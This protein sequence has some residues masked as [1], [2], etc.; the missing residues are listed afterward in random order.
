MWLSTTNMV[1]GEH[2]YD[3]W[4]GYLNDCRQC[5]IQKHCIRKP[6]K[7]RGRQVSIRIGESKHQRPNILQQMR[8]KIDSRKGRHIYSQRIGAVEP[9]FG[10]INTNKRLH[11]FSLRGKA[12]VNA[13]WL[14]YCMVHNIEKLQHNGSIV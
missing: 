12:K 11:R 5:S 2:V 3:R 8:D 14:L 13:Q 1:M 7:D 6:S 4:E 9:V 10:N